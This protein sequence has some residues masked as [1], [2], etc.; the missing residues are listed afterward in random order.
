MNTVKMM[1]AKVVVTSKSLYNKSSLRTYAREKEIAPRNP[2][3]T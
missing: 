2:P 1:T 3:Y